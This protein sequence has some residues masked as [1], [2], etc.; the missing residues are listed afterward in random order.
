MKGKRDMH[1]TASEWAIEWGGKKE[2]K[3]SEERSLPFDCCALSFTPFETPYCTEDGAVFDLVNIAP[4]LRKYKRHPLNGTP[5]AAGDLIRLN[6]HR[7]AEGKYHCPVLYK[8]F[9]ERVKIAAIRFTDEE[10]GTKTAD[11]YS[12]DAIRQLCFKPGSLRDPLTTRPFTR[13]DVI[14]LH[15]PAA[16][17]R[18]AVDR[19]EHVRKGHKVPTSADAEASVRAGN[20]P[21]MQ[22]ALARV[23]P[24][25]SKT[26]AKEAGGGSEAS[27]AAAGSE[28]QKEGRCLD[29]A[30]PASMTT[31][32]RTT[33]H[34]AAGFTSTAFDPVTAN[35]LAPVT[36]AEEADARYRKAKKLGKKGYVRLTTTKGPLNLELHV[37]MAPRTCDNFLTLCR[38]GAYGG[39]IFHR[40]VKGFMIQGGALLL[41]GARHGGRGAFTS[42]A[43]IPSH[44]QV[45]LRVRG[46][47]AN[48]AGAR[49]SRTNSPA[50]SRTTVAACS[51][52][53]TWGR[54]PTTRSSSSPSG[55]ASTSMGSI[56]SSGASS[57][58]AP[59]STPSSRYPLTAASGPRS[60]WKSSRRRF[61]RTRLK[62][63]TVLSPE[64]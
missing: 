31:W 8:E 47:V 34:C 6:F 3:R 38:R 9:S 1:I 35:K 58:A 44:L 30:A 28:A 43:P 64:A 63:W 13:D 36:A 15:D 49:T 61:S 54:T 59:P 5:L 29:G 17:D 37:D 41:R 39:T 42:L 48:H 11:V 19:F 53:P 7:N 45:T 20:N 23:Q 51:A 24:S 33:H 16:P 60:A 26:P 57:E 27:A 10:T 55:R 25:C 12:Y 56:P 4:Y 52:W 21:G 18:R 50:A 32:R 22:R 40:L 14:V 2:A 62:S 46:K